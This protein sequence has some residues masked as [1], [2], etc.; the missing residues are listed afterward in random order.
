MQGE[1]CE[2]ENLPVDKRFIGFDQRNNERKN[3]NAQN[4]DEQILGVAQ[5]WNK[6][7]VERVAGRRRCLLIHVILRRLKS[8]RSRLWT[9][10]VNNYF[11]CR[12]VIQH[13]Q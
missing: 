2:A 13:E 11:Q 1:R 9:V 3:L 5:I 8:G 6:T 10:A 7:L 4:Y 12:W